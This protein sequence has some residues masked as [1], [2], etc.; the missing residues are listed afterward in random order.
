MRES[1][2]M[3]YNPAF[4]TEQELV[5]SFVVR[6][7]DL[8]S[9]LETVRENDGQCNQHV[10]VV[11]PR[12]IGKTMLVLRAVTAVRGDA[13]LDARWYPLV[14]GEE[15]YQV[16]SPGEFWLEA[17]F[18]LA[19]R[20]DDARWHRTFEELSA[21]SNEIRLRE[22]ALAQLLDFATEEGKRILLVVEN[23]NMLL[24]EQ[25][26]D[27]DAWVLR[28]TL[29]NEKRLML[30]ATATTRFEQIDSSG[31]AMFDLFKVHTLSPLDNKEC[32]AVW[33]FAT[34]HKLD[35][36]RVRPIRILTGGN[37][38]LLTIISRFG[39]LLS[40]SALMNDLTQ[41][42]DD[43]TDI[44]I[45]AKK[46]RNQTA[47]RLQVRIGQVAALAELGEDLPLAPGLRVD[48]DVQVH[49]AKGRRLPQTH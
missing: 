15:S 1:R 17:L 2:T 27:D 29:L 12:G 49:V 32:Q 31:K 25:V 23:L 9:I 16:A 5:E 35:D 22:R 44:A 24:G 21:E 7:T 19:Q 43:H 39:A 42:V 33:S 34:G 8:E 28:H 48:T 45:Q 6:E 47:N 30:L 36:G 14:F 3:K 26:T 4:L 20:T 37:P 11:G 18:H 40:L 13:E 46:E 38:R 10:L 41:L